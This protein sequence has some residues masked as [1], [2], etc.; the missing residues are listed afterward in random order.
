MSVQRLESVPIVGMDIGFDQLRVALVTGGG[1]DNSP[2]ATQAPSLL[3]VPDG[4]TR[5]PITL[6]PPTNTKESGAQNQNKQDS[7][8]PSW[9][10]VTAR[11]TLH[12][13]TSERL[14]SLHNTPL[15]NTPLHNTPSDQRASAPDPIL[16]MAERMAQLHRYLDIQ[17]AEGR[18][19]VIAVPTHFSER[20]R[21]VW[22]D[23]AWK[24]GWEYV[25]LVQDTLASLL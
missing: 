6:V 11:A 21:A 12:L 8:L 18:R 19:Y 15:H 17:Q 9:Q 2:R 24:A 25:R 4:L 13:Q 23:T 5:L 1:A 22:R 16:E 7:G 20:Q 14:S 3:T 10:C